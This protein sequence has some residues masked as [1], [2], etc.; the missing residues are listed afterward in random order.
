MHVTWLIEPRPTTI[1]NSPVSTFKIQQLLI[2]IGAI[3]AGSTL[4]PGLQFNFL[5]MGNKAVH[6]TLQNLHGIIQITDIRNRF[7]KAVLITWISE[8]A[9]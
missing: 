1:K 5:R 9:E 6:N 7:G 4:L 2:Y 8:L 3:V